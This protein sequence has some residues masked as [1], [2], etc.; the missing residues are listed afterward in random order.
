MRRGRK[1]IAKPPQVEQASREALQ[2]AVYAL[3][4]RSRP[5]KQRLAQI[6]SDIAQLQR[7]RR[8]INRLL[9]FREKKPRKDLLA[10]LRI[11][12]RKFREASADFAMIGLPS[13]DLA[14]LLSPLDQY[15]DY[16]SGKA[17][18]I[19]PLDP[20]F[21][22][23]VERMYEKHS[24]LPVPRSKPAF[25][26]AFRA[27]AAA[28]ES[29]RWIPARDLALTYTPYEYGKNAESAVKSMD[30]A[31]RRMGKVQE[32]CLKQGIPSPFLQ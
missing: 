31:L 32:R 19:G 20:S 27:R 23:A 8:F 1:P 4:R 2:R 13:E 7:Q 25:V 5:L 17:Q 26:Q 16:A 10:V 9:S 14:R 29:G 15:A 22:G 30:R 6:K 11:D 3:V 12:P 21:F 24:T 28:S 18:S